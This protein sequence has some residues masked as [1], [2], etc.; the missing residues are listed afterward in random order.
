MAA[1]A[2]AVAGCAVAANAVT[3][4]SGEHDVVR[5]CLIY[6]FSATTCTAVKRDCA[7]FMNDQDRDLFCYQT[8]SPYF[9]GHTRTEAEAAAFAAMVTNEANVAGCMTAE[10]S[11]KGAPQ[12]STIAVLEG[13]FPSDMLA[14]SF[15][16]ALPHDTATTPLPGMSCVAPCTTDECDRFC[17]GAGCASGCTGTRCGSGCT[18][19]LCAAGCTG[20]RCGVG[21]RGRMAATF[22]TG[23]QCGTGCV[24]GACAENC[25]AHGCGTMCSGAYCASMCGINRPETRFHYGCGAHCVGHNC[26]YGCKGVGC[27]VGAREKDTDPFTT[28]C[29][30][31]MYDAHCGTLTELAG[32]QCMWTGSKCVHRPDNSTIVDGIIGTT[33][34]IGL[35][36]GSAIT[37]G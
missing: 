18:A 16:R 30:D 37:V 24:G 23:T 6:G 34:A 10:K 3:D 14:P 1:L 2:W 5:D 32:L 4:I 22:C 7:P 31:Y 13:P 12:Q 17:D 21:S 35:A 33:V 11:F 25:Q 27:G 8:S 28:T 36:A 29:G 15:P 20:Y 9:A 19:D 26:A